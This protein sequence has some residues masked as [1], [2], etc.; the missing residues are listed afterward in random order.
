M[1]LEY[2]LIPLAL[3][4][5]WRNRR[6]LSGWIGFGAPMGA[7]W[8]LALIFSGDPRYREPFDI[9]IVAGAAGGLGDLIDRFWPA[10]Q[11]AGSH[12]LAERLRRMRD[13][14]SP[15]DT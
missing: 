15:A 10:L 14:L 6:E 5:M 1:L 2:L 13:P 9:F 3:M 11:R 7:I 8:G 4:G 12:W